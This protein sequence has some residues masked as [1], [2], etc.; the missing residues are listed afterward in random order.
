MRVAAANAA[1]AVTTEPREPYRI[2]V[3]GT[4]SDDE[5]VRDVAATSLARY[6]PRIRVSPR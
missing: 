2:L 4:Y 6:R 5:L 3:E 1:L